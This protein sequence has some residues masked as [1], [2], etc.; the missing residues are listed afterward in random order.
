MRGVQMC[1]LQTIVITFIATWS[2]NL[3]Y[4]TAARRTFNNDSFDYCLK[5]T[6]AL[7]KSAPSWA[8]NQPDNQNGTQDCIHMYINKTEKKALLTDR[9]CNNSFIF[10]CQVWK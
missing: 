2:Y 10:S 8:L 4:W 1:I 6:T 5:N 7:S 3:N 9:N